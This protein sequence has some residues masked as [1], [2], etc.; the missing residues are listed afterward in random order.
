MFA[1]LFVVVQAFEVNVVEQWS[2]A[3]WPPLR[4]HPVGLLSVVSAA[5]SNIVSNVPAVLLFKPIIP[6]LPAVSREAH[7]WPWPCRVPWPAT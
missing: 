1:G 4:E 6:A 3:E 7:G 5:L 2:L